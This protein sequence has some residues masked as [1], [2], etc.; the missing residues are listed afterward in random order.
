MA[1]SLSRGGRRFP[2]LSR[3]PGRNVNPEMTP[4]PH[5]RAGPLGSGSF[6]TSARLATRGRSERH[7]CRPRLVPLA[8]S[9]SRFEPRSRELGGWT[10]GG[11]SPSI[12][13]PDF[14]LWRAD[15]SLQAIRAHES[16]RAGTVGSRPL[17]CKWHTSCAPHAQH[18]AEPSNQRRDVIPR[19]LGR[20]RSRAGFRLGGRKSGGSACRAVHGSRR[21]RYCPASCGSGARRWRRENLPSPPLTTRRRARGCSARLGS[22][23]LE[24]RG[25]RRAHQRLRGLPSPVARSRRRMA[26]GSR[27]DR[28]VW[29]RAQDDAEPTSWRG[30]RLV[31]ASAVTRAR[32]GR[33]CVSRER[34]TA[35][36]A[37]E[38]AVTCDRAGQSAML[39]ARFVREAPRGDRRASS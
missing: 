30:R 28:P 34:R 20:N 39:T 17:S 21:A 6:G 11:E 38:I 29:Q 5:E 24:A 15:P 36:T 13:S 25:T 27:R 33:R 23:G 35:L 16:R 14:P 32:P 4:A 37:R 22:V 3:S 18:R 10:T 31:L 12:R 7:S 1:Q 19:A 2:L 9:P 8:L 26:R